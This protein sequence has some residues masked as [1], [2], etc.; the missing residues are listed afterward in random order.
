MSAYEYIKDHPGKNKKLS[1]HD[2]IMSGSFSGIA[3][4]RPEFAGIRYRRFGYIILLST[5]NIEIIK[6]CALARC[7]RYRSTICPC[8]P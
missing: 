3:S 6:V 8:V 1:Q 2:A 5:S 7:M 4:L